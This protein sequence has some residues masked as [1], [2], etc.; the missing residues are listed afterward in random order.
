M[1]IPELTSQRR[2]ML[3]GAAAAGLLLILGF[4][5]APALDVAA[6]DEDDEALAL[7]EDHRDAGPVLDQPAEP[8]PFRRAR[9]FARAEDT[10]SSQKRVDRTRELPLAV[11]DFDVASAE[12]PVPV[13]PPAYQQRLELLA[14]EEAALLRH[15]KRRTETRPAQADPVPTVTVASVEEMDEPASDVE[16][17]LGE[18]RRPERW[19]RVA[20]ANAASD[21]PAEQA[22]QPRGARLSG[23]IEI[24]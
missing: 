3:I 22:F 2:K 15:H 20:L 10:S 9:A 16:H 6:D 5:F 12:T 11:N 24:D 13:T 1:D 7:V 19:R 14:E 21:G 23:N 8:R 4:S 17:A 18:A